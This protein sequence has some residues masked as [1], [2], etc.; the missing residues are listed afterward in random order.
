MKISTAMEAFEETVDGYF[1]NINQLLHFLAVLP[2]TTSTSERS[3][4]PLKIIKP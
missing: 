4:S 1:P 2:V 3:F